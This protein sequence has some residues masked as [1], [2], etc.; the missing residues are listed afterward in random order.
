MIIKPV[1]TPKSKDEIYDEINA[2]SHQI[3]INI[4]RLFLY[5]YSSY[6]D[7]W[8][9][10]IWGFLFKVNTLEDSHKYPSEEFIKSALSTHNDILKKYVKFVKSLEEGLFPE[11]IDISTIDIS[12]IENFIKDYQDYVSIQL[13]EEGFLPLENVKNK[14][15]ELINKYKR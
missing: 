11:D 15:D 1:D 8:K 5:P 10:D 2:V 13:S 6:Q 7:R 14:L 9:N 12:T 3:D 4:I